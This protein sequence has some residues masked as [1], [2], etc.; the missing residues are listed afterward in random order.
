MAIVRITAESTTIPS[1][2]V[3]VFHFSVDDPIVTSEV[4]ECVD[5]LDAFY[6][7][8]K[9]IIYG[10]VIR[11]GSRVVTVGPP[12]NQVISVTPRDTTTTGSSP[13]PYSASAGVTWRTANIGKSYTG[14]SYLG[15]LALAALGGDGLTVA[16]SAVTIVQNAANNL[17]LPT[18]NGGQL[19]VWSPTLGVATDVTGAQARPGLRTQRR[20][21]T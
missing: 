1:L 19:V 16:S 12:P 10:S 18:A 8:I 2:V 11:C 4:Q 13:A 5:Q 7:A 15:P 17:L 6:E 9:G 20:R 3:N 21:L 14:R